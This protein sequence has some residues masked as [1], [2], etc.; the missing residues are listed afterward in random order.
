MASPVIQILGVTRLLAKF[1]R[2]EE[3]DM[4]EP[5]GKATAL[6]QGSAKN[7]AAV[8][9]G[10]LRG[11]IHKEVA[12]SANGSTIGRV[13]TNLEYAPFVEFGTGKKGEGTYPY[14]IKGV[15]LEYRQ[16]PWAFEKDGEKIWTA[17]QVAQPFLFPAIKENEAKIKKLLRDEYTILLAKR[18]K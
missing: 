13:F 3:I 18:M 16:T 8:D 6:V 5:V 15:S 9:T 2:L 17:G 12:R 10:A 7:N 1:E 14:S 4:T 11:S